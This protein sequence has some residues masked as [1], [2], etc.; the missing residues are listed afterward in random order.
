MMGAAYKTK[1]DL[2]AHIG[3]EPRLIETSLFGAEYHGDGDYTVV[4][5]DPYTKRS[6]YARIT[7]KDGKIYAIDGHRPKTPHVAEMRLTR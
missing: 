2:I 7:V 4:G 1:K 6:W 5:P 3:Q